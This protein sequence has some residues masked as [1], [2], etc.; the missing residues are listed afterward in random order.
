MKDERA[1][2]HLQQ[3]PLPSDLSLRIFRKDSDGKLVNRGALHL[4]IHNQPASV[5]KDLTLRWGDLLLLSSE[6]PSGKTSEALAESW[7]IANSDPFD[8][9]VHVE[10]G[11]H[12]R[13]MRLG[14]PP[15]MLLWSTAE[16]VFPAWDLSDLVSHLTAG[17]PSANLQAVKIQRMV[18]N[19]QQEWTV[20][21]RPPAS[22]DSGATPSGAR[23]RVKPLPARLADGDR[24][25][26]PLRDAHKPATVADRRTGIFRVAPGGLPGERVFQ[27]SKDDPRPYTLC[28][29]FC[30]KHTP[31]ARCSF[32]SLISRGS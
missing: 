30:C 12:R 25:I 22:A 7:L 24:I 8:R 10:V 28:E 6:N 2:Q 32:P 29:S 26:I 3:Y 9:T 18:D 17:T 5:E 27:W 23:N 15:G 14:L 31:S 19:K 1:K 4:Y 21:L 11:E 13:D 16:T 20:D